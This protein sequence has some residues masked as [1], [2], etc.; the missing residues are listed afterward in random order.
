MTN[1]ARFTITKVGAY[2][3]RYCVSIDGLCA[4]RLYDYRTA[5]A[6]RRALVAFANQHGM[7]AAMRK[8]AASV[9]FLVRAA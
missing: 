4:S 3:A 8:A 5:C 6:H 2:N 9:R 7:D 1:E